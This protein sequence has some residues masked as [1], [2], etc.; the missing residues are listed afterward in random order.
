ML[1]GAARKNPARIKARAGEPAP[2][3]GS[4]E[5]P[6]KFMIFHPDLGYQEA[7]KLRS[8]WDNCLK[9]WPWLTF[10]DRDAL[11]HYCKLKLKEDRNTLTNAELS[12]IVKMRTELGGTGSGRARLNVGARFAQPKDKP[13]SADPRQAFLTK[14]YG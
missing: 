5:P 9:M 14:K 7:E 11:E 12:A 13:A 2:V 8:I 3:H 10:S 6:P 1:S 4:M